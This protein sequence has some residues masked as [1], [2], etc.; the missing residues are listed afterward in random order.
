MALV[1][2]QQRKAAS[3]NHHDKNNEKNIVRDLSTAPAWIG[4][5]DLS[6]V[7]LLQTQTFAVD[8]KA[9]PRKRQWH[10]DWRELVIGASPYSRVRKSH[11]PHQSVL[12]L[13]FEKPT[14]KVESMPH[15]NVWYEELC[16]NS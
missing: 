15:A 1:R 5:P 6:R 4:S 7:D 12:L 14:G 16:I 8:K 13:C 9:G 3:Q 11:T 10:E 2:G